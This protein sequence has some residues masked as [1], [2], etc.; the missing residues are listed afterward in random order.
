M[1]SEMNRYDIVFTGHVTLDQIEAPEGSARGVPGGA[2]YFGAYAACWAKKKIA[3]ITRMAEEDQHI[4]EPLKAVGIDIYLQPT[5]STTHMR[6]VHPTGNVD[7]RVMVQTEDAGFF[8]IEDILPIESRLIHLGALTDREFTLGFMR[9]LK[10]RGFRLSVD[11]QSFVRQV[12]PKSG[13]IHFND[14]PAKREIVGLADIV[15]LDI[16]EAEIMTGTRNMEKAAALVEEWG[17]IE[18]ILTFSDGVF[19][20]YKGDTFFEKFSNRNSQGRT[21]RGD[22]VMGAYLVRRIDHDVQMSLGFAAALA[23]IKMETPGPFRG[24]LEDV[25]A[26][27]SNNPPIQR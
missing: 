26:R 3:V 12:D 11:M 10:Q 9:D 22:T 18:T 24:S 5:H 17:A 21:G 6:V 8:V 25:L 14:V 20:R 27:M 15:K 19:A 4:L 13:I 23:S 2:P 7:E 1:E 16:I